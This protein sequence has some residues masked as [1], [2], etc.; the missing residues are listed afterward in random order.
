VTENVNGSP[1]NS[2]SFT[3]SHQ[4]TA[5]HRIPHRT[6]HSHRLTTSSLFALYFA[7]SD[8]FLHSPCSVVIDRCCELRHSFFA[9][10]NPA[11]VMATQTAT[12]TQSA[13]TLRGSADTVSEFFGQTVDASQNKQRL[14]SLPQQPTHPSSFSTCCHHRIQHQ[15]V[16]H[17]PAPSFALFRVSHVTFLMS[18]LPSFPFLLCFLSAFCSSAVCTTRPPSRDRL[19]TASGCR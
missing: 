9:A 17:N 3:S 19:S 7:F 13:I 8:R 2:R 18:S 5:V 11:V 4:C 12:I 15:Q 14:A 16:T 1:T 6:A 10:P